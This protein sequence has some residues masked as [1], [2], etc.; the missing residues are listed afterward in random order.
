MSVSERV[1]IRPVWNDMFIGS[2]VSV[3]ERVG[4]RPVWN[5]MFVGSA[6]SVSEQWVSDRCGMTCF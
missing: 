1:G 2:A 4:I 6:V 5:D 3:S